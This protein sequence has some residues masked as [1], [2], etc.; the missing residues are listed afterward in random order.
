MSDD[1]E[2]GADEP[3]RPQPEIGASIPRRG[4]LQGLLGGVGAGLALPLNAATHPLH[5]HEGD[6]ARIARTKAKATPRSNTREFLD[7]H[8]FE[9]FASMAERIIPGAAKA[10]LAAF[11]DHLL[12]ADTTEH[13]RRFLTALGALEGECI[14][15]FSRPWTG[16]SEAQQVEVLTVASAG[17]R[18]EEDKQW[19]P[20]DPIPIHDTPPP[21]SS[22]PTTLRDHFDVLKYWVVD[23]YYSS[24]AGMR[25]LGWT[26]QQFFASFPGCPH[27]EGHG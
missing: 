7:A 18:G 14:A 20:G 12:A 23:I 19:T 25:E 4:M 27:P 16:L 3:D 11:V 10:G 17:K 6:A 2:R 8:T 24:E 9:T 1:P 21:S 15:R 13:Q 22:T 5:P 26:G